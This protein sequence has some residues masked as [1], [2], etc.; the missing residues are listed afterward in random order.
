MPE[1]AFVLEVPGE[2]AL[3]SGEPNGLMTQEWSPLHGLADLSCGL[4]QSQSLLQSVL[5]SLLWGE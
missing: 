1:V 4:C 2:A 3:S 5:L